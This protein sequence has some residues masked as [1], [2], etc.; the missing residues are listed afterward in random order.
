MYEK[1]MKKLLAFIIIFVSTTGF[2]FKSD[3]EKCADY[4]FEKEPDSNLFPIAIYN[5]TSRTKEE[6]KKIREERSKKTEKEI[7]R[8][9]SLPLCKGGIP[10]FGLRGEENCRVERYP[11]GKTY[12]E[13]RRGV[14][15]ILS[16]SDVSKKVKIKDIPASEIKLQR[17]KFLNKSLKEKLN[18]ADT[19]NSERLASSRYNELYKGCINEKKENLTLFKA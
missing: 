6:I 4:W 8:Y 5:L 11:S 1:I 7:K 18:L 9:Q 15:K 10:G 3:L 13:V 17:K 16:R 12:A 19:Q 14:D 2:I